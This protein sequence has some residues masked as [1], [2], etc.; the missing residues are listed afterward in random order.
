MFAKGV[1][2]AMKK[3]GPN[4]DKISRRNLLQNYSK[5]SNDRF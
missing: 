1:Q 2:N 5:L 3:Y 4:Q